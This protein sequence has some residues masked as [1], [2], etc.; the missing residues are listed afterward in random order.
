MAAD[1][2]DSSLANNSQ[3]PSGTSTGGNTSTT[4]VDT[5]QSWMPDQWAGRT[6]LIVGGTGAGQLRTIASNAAHQLA[7]TTAWTTI[8][9]ATSV[10]AFQGDRTRYVYDGFDRLN[11]VIDSV[12][13]QTVYQYDPA[14]DIVRELDFGPV[15]GPSPTSDGPGTLTG[16]VSLGGVIQAANLVSSNLLSATESSY[17]ELGRCYQTSQVL[18]V[19]TIPTV[20]P[21]DVAEGAGDIGL[22]SL[23]PG[24][25]RPIPGIAGITIL[26]R[27]T[28]RAE[29]DR[30]SRPNFTVADDLATTRTFYDGDGRAI[31]TV[32]PEGN[33]FETAYDG[34]DNVIETRQTDVSQVAGVAPEVFLT[35]YFYDSLNRLQEA[36][37]NLGETIHDR[38]DSRGNLVAT[39]DANGPVGPTIAR[40]AF[41]DGPRTVDA[42]NLFGNVTL[43]SYDGLDRQTMQEQILTSSGEGD[44][45]HIGASIYGIK[46]DPTAPE[47]FPPPADPSQ[48][49]GDGIIRTGTVWDGNSLPA[50]VIDDNGNVTVYVQDDL[51]RQVAVTTGLTVNTRL[52]AGV[53]LGSEV[54]PTPT[55]ATVDDP[56]VIAPAQIN[57]QLAETQARLTA[58]AALFPPLASE[59]DPPTTATT[60]YDPSDNALI[61]QDQNGS[62]I[63]TRYDA[64]GRAIAVRVFRAG[65]HDSF[66][67]DPI[68]APRRSTS[69]RITD[70]DPRSSAPRSRT[71]STTGSR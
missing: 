21:A 50:A 16:P 17:D 54:I 29:Y 64:I 23:T 22:G 19:N 62:E 9:D 55:A 57:A 60:G 53:I 25:T 66:A 70:P 24:Q 30:D 46:D 28:D 18:F 12:G 38:Y 4:L 7:V 35:T 31:E 11:S 41:P 32:D 45:V 39:A 48:G 5:H 56:A 65:Q 67:G 40:R 2:T 10:Y 1:D 26:G 34:D 20:R 52:S 42:T 14:G 51:D 8:P 27:V 36:V 33:T 69:S 44:G 49:G 3:L 43:Y 47:S 6:V 15:G 58:V 59:I 37:D 13:D 63:F 68:F 61:R 71:S